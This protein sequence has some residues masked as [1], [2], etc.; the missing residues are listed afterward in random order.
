MHTY[1][2]GLIRLRWRLF[3]SSLCSLSFPRKTH[4]NFQKNNCAIWF[5]I[6][7]IFVLFLLINVYL[8]FNDFWSLD[9]F[10]FILGYFF[11][12]IF[13]IGF[14]PS[15]FNCSI[16]IL[17]IFLDYF[18]CNF[19]PFNFIAF[20]FLIYFLS[21]FIWLLYSYPF[22]FFIY[23]SPQYLISFGFLS[24]F[25]PFSLNNFFLKSF[26]YSFFFNLVLNYFLLFFFISCL[27]CIIWVLNC[28]KVEYFTLL[29]FMVAFQHDSHLLK[30]D[31]FSSNSSFDIWLLN[32]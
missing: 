9:F 21:S 5:V 13:L 30:C 24:S 19:I 26:S 23:F 16:F 15:T 2:G 8:A 18:F 20:V 7:S 29:F 12:L 32:S 1:E 14:D 28:F 27:I 3:L 25:G 22:L 6:L 10:N 4:M 31:F 17:Y 11:N